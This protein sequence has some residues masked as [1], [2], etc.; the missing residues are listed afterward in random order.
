MVVRLLT[1][2]DLV[3]PP[4]EIGA[5]DVIVANAPHVIASPPKAGAAIS[6]SGQFEIA[7][8]AYASSQ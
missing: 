5:Y 3:K 6:T 2:H 1:I 7:S 8:S 4:H